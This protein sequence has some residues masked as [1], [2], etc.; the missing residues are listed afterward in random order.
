MLHLTLAG[1]LLNAVGG[2]PNLTSDDFVPLYP[3]H[4]PT[5]QTTFEV[6]I[7]KFSLSAI[8]NFLNI[9][10]PAPILSEHA[11]VVKL[12]ENIVTIQGDHIDESISESDIPFVPYETK[13]DGSYELYY[14]VAIIPHDKLSFKRKQTVTKS[15][16]PTFKSTDSEGN[17][18]ELHYWSIGEFYRAISLGFATLS[19]SMPPEEL[20]CGDPKRQFGRKYYYSGGGESFEVTD[21]KSAMAAIELI[22]GQGEGSH[23]KVYDDKNEIAHY[24]RFNQIIQGRYYRV[25]DNDGKNGD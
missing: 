13:E 5:G 7:E 14:K 6:N 22:A 18:I 9:E 4:L 20:F 12:V 16:L 25:P 23:E 1:N 11:E 19:K 10:R 3:T 17:E 21:L 8:Q 15:F 2:E 24:Y